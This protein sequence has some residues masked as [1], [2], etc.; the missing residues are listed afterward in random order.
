MIDK[1]KLVALL[2]G[3]LG[4]QLTT[5]Q[6][7]DL[8]DRL[9]ANQQPTQGELEKISRDITGTRLITESLDIDDVITLLDQAGG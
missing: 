4:E 5:Q 9:I 2:K 3:R 8:A 7:Y 6:I 1:V